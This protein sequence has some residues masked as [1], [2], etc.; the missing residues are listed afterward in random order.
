[1]VFAQIFKPPGHDP[2]KIRKLDRLF[3]DL[4]YLKIS[5]T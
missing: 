4:I 5:K 3:W 2:V 1:M